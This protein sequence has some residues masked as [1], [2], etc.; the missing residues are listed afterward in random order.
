MNER[1]GGL[2]LFA[3]LG[4]CS[5]LAG[6]APGPSPL[7]IAVDATDAPQGLFRARL[8]VPAKPGP[9]TLAYP[10]W[11]QGEHSPFGP[12]A[13]LA[14][15]SFTTN[16]ARIPWRRDPL[17]LYL[18]HLEVPRG[19]SSVTVDLEYLSPAQ[20]LGPGYGH[21]P[22]ATRHLLIV[23][24]NNLVLYPRGTAANA[25][26]IQAHLRLPSGWK[27][28]AALETRTEP[29]SSL[30]FA[31]TT[32]T[33]LLDSPVLAGDRLQTI[34]L[35][36]GARPV[37]MTVAVDRASPVQIP[38]ELLDAYRKLVREAGLLFGARHYRSYHWLIALGDTLERNG[39]EHAEST[40]I[41]VPLGYFTDPTVRT[42]R[43]YL[44]PHEFVHSWNGK[45]RRPRGL[46][47]RDPHQPLDGELL[48]VYEG[49][50]RYLDMVL[51]A[52]SG[53]SSA[54]ET[55]EYLAWRVARQERARGGRRWRPVVDTAISAQL[56]FP[57]PA[58]WSSERRS[59]D[60]YD[61]TMLVW[62]EVDAI[63]RDRS[64]GKHSLDDFCRDFFGGVDGP[65]EVRPFGREDLE[66]ALARVAPF[67]WHGFFTTRLYE[68]QPQ[69]S[70]EGLG[71]AGW[72]LVYDA[73]PNGFGKAWDEVEKQV[74]RTWS[75]GLLLDPSGE[76]KDVVVGS[77]AWRAGVAQG[78]KIVAVNGTKFT[79][80]ALDDALTSTSTQSV[81]LASTKNPSGS[82]EFSV[83]LGGEAI[84]LQIEYRAGPQY[85]HLVRDAAQ[86]D[87]LSVIL[88]SRSAP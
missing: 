79:P 55:R 38:P 61:E 81:A 29:D 42:A 6:A 77:A 39:L 25:L 50:T 5:G 85:P 32:L 83:E 40:D 45:Y 26:P 87:L 56:L 20:A 23:D 59:A 86:P 1:S 11:I 21:T 54:D 75:V 28:D 69:L 9:L 84:R 63:L 88:A 60:Y 80:Q 36:P 13:R 51:A 16:G 35:D 46:V 65:P 7:D 41:R 34:Q 30:V 19:S 73:R 57:A 33:T 64:G 14:G 37:W 44:I 12:I 67:D 17:D 70:L 71:R 2:L 76:V 74:D 24:W 43:Q 31:P 82:I 10:K 52:R 27:H 47:A 4:L 62:L 58:G 8:V 78:M 15:L 49:L 72:K 3:L 22:N 53:V 68:L 48:W 66:A 18:F